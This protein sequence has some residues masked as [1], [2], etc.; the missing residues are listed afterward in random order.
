MKKDWKKNSNYFMW[1][2]HATPNDQ[3]DIK[4]NPA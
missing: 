3:V 4:K 2:F 1:M